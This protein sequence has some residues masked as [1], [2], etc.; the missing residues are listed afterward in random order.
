MLSR[1][2]AGMAVR[3]VSDSPTIAAAWKL[4]SEPLAMA[5]MPALGV[6]G[7]DLYTESEGSWRWVGSGQPQVFPSN[8]VTLANLPAARRHFIL[9]LP[10]YNG[11]ESVSLGIQKDAMIGR[12]PAYPREAAKPVMF[13]GTSIVQGGC[14]SRPGLAYPAIIGRRLRRPI[15]NIGFSGNGPMDLE[16][17]PLMAEVDASVY[18][19]DCLPNM[20]AEMVLERTEPF[21]G[22]LRNAR[23]RTPIVIVEN[24]AWQNTLP[25]TKDPD[26]IRKNK[27][28]REA[29]NRLRKAGVTG[30][31]RVPYGRLLGSD[32]EG[33]VDGVH[34]NDI[35]FL[36]MA[37][38]LT[39]A[40]EKVL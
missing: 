32:W 4:R 2:S 40:I 36:R 28:L 6:S 17:A 38:V 30:L 5:H 22:T 35:G 27:Y 1:N 37:G 19:L 3:F 15:I 34:P 9:Y 12:A 10:L 16:I 14:A 24:I 18:V 8:K 39:P 33:T 21:I 13:Y 25:E 26:H 20:S 29:I 31:H 23:P 7:L 11:V